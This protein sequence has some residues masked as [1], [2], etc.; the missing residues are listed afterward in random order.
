[1]FNFGQ[2]TNG[3]CFQSVSY[4]FSTSNGNVN[5]FYQTTTQVPG[6]EPVTNTYTTPGTTQ[7]INDPT[8]MFGSFSNFFGLPN[9]MFGSFFGQQQQQQQ[10]INNTV[11]PSP[12]VNEMN[13]GPEIEDISEYLEG[14]SF[15]SPIKIEEIEDDDVTEEELRRIQEME[16]QECLLRDQMKANQI[17]EEEDFKRVQEVETCD[18]DYINSTSIPFNNNICDDDDVDDDADSNIIIESDNELRELIRESYLSLNYSENSNSPIADSCTILVQLPNGRRVEHVFN[19]QETTWGEVKTWV[20]YELARDKE[21]PTEE[22][23]LENEFEICINYPFIILSSTVNID[24]KLID[25]KREVG[26]K[27]LIHIR[28]ND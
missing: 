18:I 3:R 25:F 11:Q 20:S 24:K 17:E 6:Q 15:S 27:I 7:Q 13:E 5:Q 2:N 9:A 16:Y 4:S 28:K 10:Q 21:I 19:I 26:R 8:S 14:D 22:F 1:M 23:P 12:E